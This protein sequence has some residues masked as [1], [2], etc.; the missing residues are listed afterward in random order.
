[1][2]A[3]LAALR[4]R[5]EPRFGAMGLVLE[6]AVDELPPVERLDEGAM[7]MLQYLLFEAIS[8]VLQHARASALRVEATM[9]GP[10]LRIAVIDNGDGFDTRRPPRSLAERARA[11]GARL[12]LQS[13][14]GRTVVWLEIDTA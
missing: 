1:M 12:V 4:Y 2:G 9:Q 7:R 10:V 14:P 5:L 8:N 6:W 11:L 13:R 3:L